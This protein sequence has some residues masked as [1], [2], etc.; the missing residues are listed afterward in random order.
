MRS[1]SVWFLV[2][3]IFLTFK[4]VIYPHKITAEGMLVGGRNYEKNYAR[5]KIEM[6]AWWEI[7]FGGDENIL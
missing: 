2:H 3:K 6:R 1:H 5:R 4:L 7:S